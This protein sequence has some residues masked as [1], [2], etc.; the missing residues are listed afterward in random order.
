M[1]AK[2]RFRLREKN[3]EDGCCRFTLHYNL[4]TLKQRGKKV[5]K[6]SR[7]NKTYYRKSINK[8]F[9][10]RMYEY[11][12]IL[13]LASFARGRQMRKYLNFIR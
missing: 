5:A 6:N 10:G 4:F 2:L 3:M 7:K 11:T 13:R 8:V 9:P 1:L 12:K